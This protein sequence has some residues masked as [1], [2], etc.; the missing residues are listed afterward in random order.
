MRKRNTPAESR[1]D[2]S[3]ILLILIFAAVLYFSGAFNGGGGISPAPKPDVPP[4]VSELSK[5]IRKAL[6]GTPAGTATRYAAFYTIAGRSIAID[7]QNTPIPKLRARMERAKEFLQLQSN[8]AFRAIVVRELD[9]FAEGSIDR[10]AYAAAF[11]KL[12]DGCRGAE[13]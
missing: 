5:E 1:P 3:P 7:K 13:P 2:N 6:E 4:E 9:K 11:Q 10:S 8:D 12:G